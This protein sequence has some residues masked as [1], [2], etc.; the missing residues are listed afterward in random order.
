[1][2]EQVVP[3]VVSLLRAAVM[4]GAADVDDDKDDDGIKKEWSPPP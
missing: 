1:M 3:C 4:N 2:K